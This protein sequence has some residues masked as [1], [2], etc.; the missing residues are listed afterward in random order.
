MP[1][2]QTFPFRRIFVDHMVRGMTNVWWQLDSKF[3]EPG[4]H[5]FQL[6][7]SKTP[8]GDSTDWR[9][10]GTPVVDG[11]NATDD[12]WR[13][14][15]GQLLTHYRVTLTTATN[16]Y[17]SEPV[18]VYGLLSER[19]W[20]IAQ[21][22]IRKER[23]RNKYTSVP[24]VLLKP[25]R[26]GERCI[27]R[28]ELTDEPTDSNCPICSGTGFKVGWHPP[29]QMQCWDISP[30]TVAETVDNNMKGTTR[31]ESIITARVIGFPA[32]SKW[33]VW[34]NGT[35]D[36]RWMVHK[37]KT[38]AAI[39]GV[40]LVYEVTMGLVPFS[41][42]IYAIEI[43]GERASRPGPVLPIEGCGNISVDHDYGGADNLAYTNASGCPVVGAE[44]YVFK[45]TDFD[46]AQPAYPDRNLA[47]AGTTTRANG[48][49]NHALKLN[50]GDYVVLYE[51]PGEYGPDTQELVVINDA[52]GSSCAWVDGLPLSTDDGVVLI[53]ESSEAIG[54]EQPTRVCGPISDKDFWDI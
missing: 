47:A 46:A 41:S 20:S 24:G 50:A 30:Q 9:N 43:G 5:T 12:A 37:I 34:V 10:V 42:G 44:I 18:S 53:D 32:L 23:L 52:N 1:H 4:P 51:K 8:I 7:V 49:W 21:E 22:I 3:N 48:H 54:I 26:F 39:R 11:Y 27:C 17:V 15:G 14:A 38:I 31:E 13:E 40:P 28:E 6:Q 16:I 33:D 29:L 35:S 2:T 45:K 25:M 36:E 19:D